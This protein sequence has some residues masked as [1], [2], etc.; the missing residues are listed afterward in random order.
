MHLCFR[1]AYSIYYMPTHP[2]ERRRERSTELVNV[3]RKAVA[4]S[5]MNHLHC[6]NTLASL[7]SFLFIDLFIDINYACRSVRPRPCTFHNLL[8][9]DIGWI[10]FSL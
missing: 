7:V 4:P 9:R 6:L 8:R 3:K 5:T 2:K 1:R 10:M